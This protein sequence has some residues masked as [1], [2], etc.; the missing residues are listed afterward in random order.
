M[1]GSRREVV[2]HARFLLVF[3]EMRS[4]SCHR[5][6][7][8]KSLSSLQI[9]LLLGIRALLASEAKAQRQLGATRVNLREFRGLHDLLRELHLVRTKDGCE[10]LLVRL[11]LLFSL[12]FEL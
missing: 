9:I 5:L 3:L 8:F 2:G 1:E 7:R 11:I 12:S 4:E 10:I 6:D